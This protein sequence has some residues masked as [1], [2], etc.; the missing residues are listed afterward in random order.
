MAAEAVLAVPVE[1]V[2]LV[3]VLAVETELEAATV[4]MVAAEAAVLELLPVLV[5]LAQSFFIGQKG[6][7]HEIR[8]D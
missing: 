2:V 3:V 7:D 8:M 5:E 4:E 6:I 1:M